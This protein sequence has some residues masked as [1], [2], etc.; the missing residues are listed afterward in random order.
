MRVL[1]HVRPA[2]VGNE[3]PTVEINVVY[4]DVNEA[5][6]KLDEA[7]QTARRRLMTTDSTVHV[8]RDTQTY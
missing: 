2:N 5:R 1:T 6:V 3:S 8:Q 4:S 7:Y